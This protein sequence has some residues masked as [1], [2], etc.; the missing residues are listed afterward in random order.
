MIQIGLVE[1]TNASNDPRDRRHSVE[2]FSC[3][4]LFFFQ[5][6][7]ILA[8]PCRLA[9]RIQTGYI[10]NA[11]RLIERRRDDEILAVVELSAHDVMIVASYDA[12]TSTDDNSIRNRFEGLY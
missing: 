12:N 1:P 9:N 7:Q 8:L 2:P 6:T 3:E 10:P 4:D 5:E 11:Y